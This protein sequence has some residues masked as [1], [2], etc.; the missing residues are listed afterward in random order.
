M[1]EWRDAVRR[2][3]ER[4]RRDTGSPC[5][6]RQELLDQALPRFERQFSDAKTPEQTMSR[7]LQELRDRDEIEFVDRGLYEIHT[8]SYEDGR[9]T[10]DV[11]EG[12][13]A[14]Y[15]AEEYDTVVGARSLPASFRRAALE[16][17]E[18]RCPVSGV[19]HAA[20]LDVAHVLPWSDYPAHRL[21]PTNVLVLDR[22][23][24]A[25][26][27]RGLFTLDASLTLRT[28]PSLDT[29]CRT[30]R[31]TLLDAEGSTVSLPSTATL[32]TSHLTERN[33]SLTWFSG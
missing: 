2:E 17:Y 26:F 13:E 25:A 9:P 22:T 33:D 16:R 11:D 19:D 7:V 18:R 28:N 31:R 4:F 3:L 1:S 20:L 14:P 6:S 5:V 24:H 30:L 27:D 8:L 29:A 15:R 10:S 23:H 12:N 32:D 21:D